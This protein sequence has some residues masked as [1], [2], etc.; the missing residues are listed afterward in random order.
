MVHAKIAK[1]KRKERKI[2]ILNILRTLRGKGLLLQPP[3][4]AG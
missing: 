4:Q 1:M 2:F 3:I